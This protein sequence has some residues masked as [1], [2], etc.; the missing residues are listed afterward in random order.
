M[1]AVKDSFKQNCPR[2][3]KLLTVFYSAVYKGYQKVMEHFM[4][5]KA[6]C[7]QRRALRNL[8]GKT[9]L[10][11][12]FFVAEV[13]DWKC[14][15]IYQKMLEASRFDPLI[16]IC[17]VINYG[18]A[19][20]QQEIQEC[21]EF[22]RKKRYDF[23]V[24]LDANTGELLNVRKEIKPDLIFYTDPYRNL[25]EDAFYIS[26]YQD[27]LGLYVPYGFNNNSEFNHSYN[28]LF[29]NIVW[30]LYVESKVHKGYAQRVSRCKGR[31]VVATGYPAIEGLIDGHTPS[32]D[33]WKIKDETIK[34]II[35]APHHTIEPVGNFSYSRFMDY[36]D[37]MLDM[38]EKYKDEVQFVFRPHPHLRK[39]LDIIWGKEKTDTYYSK[40]QNGDNTAFVEGGYEDLFLT[41]DAMIHDS[42]S[43]TVEYLFVNKPVMRTINEIPLEEQFND[44]TLRC[45]KNYYLANT[46]QKV[47]DF[48]LDVISGRDPLKEQRTAFLKDV[49][50]PGGIPSQCILDDILDSIDNQVL[51]R[52]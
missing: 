47:E 41:S 36:A 12:V 37:F 23:I 52:R 29:H 43:F 7:L 14:D 38:A 39:K 45:L 10:K 49:L 46:P 16:V 31:N 34:R 35:W 40:W 4:I 2:L 32:F 8:K 33:G 27:I 42:G 48:I 5:L 9:K 20:K 24:A 51:Y 15:R 3:F 25:T 13:A 6:P 30:R 28:L 1:S 11:C 18:E 26:S 21:E 44:F 19:N 17:P 22:F 50:M